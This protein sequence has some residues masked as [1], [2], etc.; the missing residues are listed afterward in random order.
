MERIRVGVVLAGCGVYDGAEIHESVVTL[1]A[2][3]RAGAEAL[4]M[5]PAV[6]QLHVINHLTGDVAPDEKRNVLVEAARIARGAIRD[7]ALVDP[8]E[9]DAVIIPGGFGAAKNLCDFALKGAECRVD[10]DVA[11]V[12][13]GVHEADRPIGAIC[14]AP[15][16]LAKLLG[17]EK[18]TLTIGTDRPTAAAM[19]SMGACHVDCAVRDTVVDRRKKIV[20]TPAYMLAE[21]IADAAAGI[22]KLVAEV[23]E[24]ARS[25][26]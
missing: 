5:A 22:E 4:C 10:P 16:L 15:A 2:L 20:T 26:H 3:D 17:D 24:M 21:S 14:I 18:P 1:L 11:R 9:L 8:T 6:D 23:L 7:V 12:V 13:R 25:R 19:E